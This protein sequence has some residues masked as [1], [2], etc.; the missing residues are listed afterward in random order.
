MKSR[1]YIKYILPALFLVV[2][3][4][5]VL[6]SGGIIGPLSRPGQSV[7]V[8]FL[9]VGKGDCILIRTHSYTMMIDTGY[10]ETFDK[11]DSFLKNEHV[12]GIDTLVVTH[13][14]KDHAGGVAPLLSKYKVGEIY[15]PDFESVK[16]T[17]E[18]YTAAV[19][20]SGVSEYRMQPGEGLG[21]EKDGLD[22]VLEAPQI[23]YD[24]DEKNDNDM[25]LM[26]RM[27][28]KNES[29]LF[30]GDI[31]K[32][33]IKYFLNDSALCQMD[34]GH[35]YTLVKM[36]RHGGVED[37]TD[38]LL[39]HVQRFSQGS[40]LAVITDSVADKADGEVI[41]ELKSHRFD[42]LS[43]SEDGD[44]SVKGNGTGELKILKAS[45]LE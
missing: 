32:P 28:N 34:Y 10:D 27:D 16:D 7:R 30:L 26:L 19:R 36:P 4:L 41:D 20:S 13:F 17:Y 9:D 15:A 31:E 23:V 25:S 12:E 29:W 42:Y 6:F 35:S 5:L 45:S 11:V 14:D 8:D 24:P 44:I 37:N 21:F 33:G 3:V 2:L 22:F 18:S 40:V 38:K 1:N 39:D 43:S